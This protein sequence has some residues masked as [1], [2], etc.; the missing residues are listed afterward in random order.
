MKTPSK[1]SVKLSINSSKLHVIV[2]ALF[3]LVTAIILGNI[4]VLSN[5][6]QQVRVLD[7]TS[8]KLMNETS[9]TPKHIHWFNHR[10][11]ECD[12]QLINVYQKEEVYLDTQN[13][14]RIT[15][16]TSSTQPDITRV[17]TGS[18]DLDVVVIS[19]HR[20]E[21]F[22]VGKRLRYTTLFHLKCY[23]TDNQKV[24]GKYKLPGEIG[25]TMS[26]IEV[27]R[28][29]IQFRGGVSRIL[30]LED[31]VYAVPDFQ[32][33]LNTAISHTDFDMLYL[34]VSEYGKPRFGQMN[35]VINTYKA[36]EQTMGAF[37]ILYTRETVQRLYKDFISHPLDDAWDRLLRASKLR[38][39]GPPIKDLV[40]Y[41]GITVADVRKSSIRRARNQVIHGW[42]VGW[43]M[44][45]FPTC[46][47]NETVRY[48]FVVPSYNNE[49]WIHQN[50]ASIAAQSY[51]NFRVVYI[52]DASSDNTR[53]L[54]REF[55]QT[56]TQKSSK[57]TLLYLRNRRRK[58]QAYAR[59]RAYSKCTD[60]EVCV[61]LDGDDW[62]AHE[63]ALRDIHV[64]MITRNA[65][66]VYNAYQ[67]YE[68][69]NLQNSPP[70]RDY[71]QFEKK[72]K[73]FRSAPWLAG[74]PRVF[75]AR[76]LRKLRPVNLK[77]RGE[78]LTLCTDLVESFPCLEMARNPQRLNLETPC[79]VYN[80]DNSKRYK[81]NYYKRLHNPE[82]TLYRE[83][84]ERYLRNV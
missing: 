19:Q 23:K 40:L 49:R 48:V 71:T 39:P 75:Q 69:E 2:F 15:K 84:I 76:L 53:S 51:R 27:F 43:D 18:N 44:S 67:I 73:S 28:W 29:F 63:H 3:I 54:V 26:H 12:D 22:S 34:G 13:R 50:L 45:R 56:A 42:R 8:P 24:H 32:R 60:D 4:Y 5:K 58:G 83:E 17:H 64:Y 72:H 9:R 52:D 81:N 38:L 62:M 59:Y 68:D 6:R 57:F 70:V 1:P 78:W 11:K 65:D 36:T 33:R 74:P 66:M 79:Y 16:Y 35:R 41:P 25:C 14:P 47:I 55:V 31:D 46:P 37:S 20:E 10:D 7:T 61:F 77:I 21:A 80:R 82:E 30:V